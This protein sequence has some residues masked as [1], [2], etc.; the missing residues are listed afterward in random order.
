MPGRLLI[1]ATIH[2]A[3]TF[4]TEMAVDADWLLLLVNCVWREN[5][6]WFAKWLKALCLTGAAGAH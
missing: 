5:F 4:N 1:L 3:E 2:A 6:C